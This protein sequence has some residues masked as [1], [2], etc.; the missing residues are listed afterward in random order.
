MQ[1]NVRYIKI[2][3]KEHEVKHDI[4]LVEKVCVF[5]EQF[6]LEKIK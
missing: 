6:F 2:Y 4:A 1:Y 3:V 5:K